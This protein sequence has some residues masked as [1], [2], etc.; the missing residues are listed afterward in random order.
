MNFPIFQVLDFIIKDKEP[1][2][3]LGMERCSSI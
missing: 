1:V 3:I 2:H